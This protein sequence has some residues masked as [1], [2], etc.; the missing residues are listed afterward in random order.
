[1]QSLQ[2]GASQ[3]WLSSQ[4]TPR[5]VSEVHTPD[6]AALRASGRKPQLPDPLPTQDI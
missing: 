5:M 6:T 3:A 4:Q 1:M 2:S